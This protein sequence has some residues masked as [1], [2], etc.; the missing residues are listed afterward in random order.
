MSKEAL[1]NGHAEH[2]H[3]NSDCQYAIRFDSNST[4][5][6]YDPEKYKKI[7]DFAPGKD[8]D[9][10]INNL[11]RMLSGPNSLTI[12]Q[13]DF[14]IDAYNS[15][16]EFFNI[17]ASKLYE[18]LAEKG[19]VITPLKRGTLKGIDYLDG[20]GFGTNYLGDGYLQYHPKESSHHKS[21][22]YKLSSGK[23]SHRYKTNGDEIFD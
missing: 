5:E 3:A 16:K 6:G 20:G 15:P 10:K 2:I 12:D 14:I 9:K 21:E 13:L 19:F 1:K 7:Y 11:R 4:I 23:G 8:S 17:E 22:Y 18:K